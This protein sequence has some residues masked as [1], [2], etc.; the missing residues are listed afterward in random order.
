MR[1]PWP[2]ARSLLYP[3][4]GVLVALAVL[5]VALAGWGFVSSNREQ[6]ATLEKQY[7]TRQAV[8]LA[9]EVELFFRD[10]AGRIEGV[11]QV[12]RS[13]RGS[14][15]DS[16]DSSA[17]LSD[18]VRG[19]RNVILLRLLDSSGHGPFVQSRALS[20]ATVRALEPLL[21]EAFASNLGGRPVRQ[22]LLRLPGEPPMMLVSLPLLTRSGKVE[23]AMQGVISLEE[24]AARLAEEGGQGATVDIVDRFGDVLFSSDAARVGKS[25]RTHPLVAQFLAAPVRLTKT[26]V[27]PLR[28]GHEEVLGSLCPIET[29][30]W[31]VITARDVGVAFAA[32]RGM[33]KRTAYLAIATGLV[34]TLAG[35]LLARRITLPLRNLA[36]VTSAVAGGDFSRRVPVR[37]S[38]EMGQLAANFNVMAAEIDRYVSSLREALLENQELL[39]ESIRALAAAIDAKSPYTRGHSERVSN[40]AVAV[41]RH[42]GIKEAELKKVEIAALLH[43]V[44]KI[45][46]D[47]AILGKPDVLTDSEFV[48]MRAHPLKGAAIVSPIKH[49]R[50]MLPGIRSHHEAWQGGGYPDGLVGDEIPLIAR[51]IAIADVFDAMTTHRPYQ[52]ALNLETVF[53]RMREMSGSRFDPEVVEA[54][55]AAIRD[56]DLVP[57]GR[58]EVA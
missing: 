2:F 39:V 44:G 11:A 50:D 21:G 37:S 35:I 33:A 24:L 13:E 29:P 25:A 3:L 17:I 57:L 5:P 28:L 32:V 56:G 18:V 52:R 20:A 49:L 47:D 31:A 16:A 41:A 23:G 48:Q 12:L 58:M 30:A 10:S 51:I 36:G 53:A 26:Y 43:D 14:R 9:R 45:G 1:W 46:I 6:V 38:N 7:L 42:C 55:F 34:A 40:Y 22:D 4:T 8:G 54:F 15:L 19:N 27:D